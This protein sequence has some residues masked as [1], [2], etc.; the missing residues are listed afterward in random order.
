MLPEDA[1]L[2]FIQGL[3]CFTRGEDLASLSQEP[4]IQQEGLNIDRIPGQGNEY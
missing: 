1:F 3:S 2:V 4:V